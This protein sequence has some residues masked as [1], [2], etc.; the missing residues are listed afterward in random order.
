MYQYLVD[1]LLGESGLNRAELLPR[2][3]NFPVSASGANDQRST[4]LMCRYPWGAC[5]VMRPGHSDNS[6]LRCLLLGVGF[7]DMK[8]EMRKRHEEFRKEEKKRDEDLLKEEKKRGEDLLE[9][10]KKRGED[11]QK[12]QDNRDKELL[13]AEKK[14]DED[15]QKAQV[16]RTG[17]TPTNR[18]LLLALDKRAELIAQGFCQALYRDHY[19]GRPLQD[20]SILS[21]RCA[22]FRFIEFMYKHRSASGRA[23]CSIPVSDHRRPF[24]Y[25]LDAPSTPP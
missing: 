14:R 16:P 9:E 2:S 15:R 24:I 5:H 25:W 4:I 10:E 11:L 13:E 19:F 17:T 12:E 22:A 6:Y 21:G 8:D 23:S 3:T 18:S 20:Y 7:Q 1:L